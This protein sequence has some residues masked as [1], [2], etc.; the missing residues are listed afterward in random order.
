MPFLYAGRTAFL[1][2]PYLQLPT[3]K[4]FRIFYS[5]HGITSNTSLLKIDQSTPS[6]CPQAGVLDTVLSL[7]S[8]STMLFTTASSASVLRTAAQLHEVVA[9]L[10]HLLP[11]VPDASVMVLEGLPA[12]PPSGAA[13]SGSTGADPRTS[14]LLKQPLL[15]KRLCVDL[16]PL[17]LQVHSA[18]VMQQV[19]DSCSNTC[20]FA[21]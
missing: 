1:M 3:P 18:T 21:V 5:N 19:R 12:L 8:T 17:L 2:Q 14:F 16:L 15:V 10:H 13:A 4:M 20:V 9:L 6:T 11:S 7:L